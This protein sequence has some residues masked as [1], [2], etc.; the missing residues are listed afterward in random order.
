MNFSLGKNLEKYVSNQ[1]Q[2]GMFNNASEVIRDALRMHEEY[3]LK[4][5]RLRRDINM[6]MQSIKNGNISHATAD[7]I[8][9]E[10]LGEIEG[11]E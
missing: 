4:L 2:D 9:N 7:E 11:N 8:M 3:Q 6:G 1:V 10:A 5:A